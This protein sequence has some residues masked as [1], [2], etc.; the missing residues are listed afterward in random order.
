MANKNFTKKKIQ[1]TENS[2]FGNYQEG[3]GGGGSPEPKNPAQRAPGVNSEY[4]EENND[5]MQPRTDD[6]KFTYKSVNGKSIDPKYGPSRGKTV[7][8][9]LTGGENGI[10]IAD[11]EKEFSSESGAYWDKYKDKWY[12][13]GGE[14]VTGGDFKVRV[15]A[16]AVWNVAKQAYNEVTGEFGG[17]IEFEHQLGSGNVKKGKGTDGAAEAETFAN[18]KKGRRGQEEKAA[19][20]Q[21]KSAGDENAVIAN[22][23]GGIKVKPGTPNPTPASSQPFTPP[24]TPI[25]QNPSSYTPSSSQ[26]QSPF[27]APQGQNILQAPG[28]N[29]QPQAGNN[30]LTQQNMNVLNQLF[31]GNIPASVTGNIAPVKAPN[32]S[33]K[34]SLAGFLKKKSGN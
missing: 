33:I 4:R 7:N 23:S 8:P 10:K 2:N 26:S 20:A 25:Q 27:S 21:A 28:Q 32:S 15:A 3:V 16:E 9:L 11:V 14:V 19:V 30:G 31:G 24:Q 34:P 5:T 17:N 12:R 18:T 22:T 29:N 1:D 6:G 13:K